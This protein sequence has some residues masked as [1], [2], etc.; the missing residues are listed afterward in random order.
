MKQ[1]LSVTVLCLPGLLLSGAFGCSGVGRIVGGQN[2][3]GS[4]PGSG[5]S[6]P[7][8]GGSNPGTG[9]SNPGTGGN[10]PG[11]GGSNP[12]TGGLGGGMA[13]GGAMGNST[14]AVGKWEDVTP[15]A[16]SGYSPGMFGPQTMFGDPARPGTFYFT[17]TSSGVFKSTD[18]GK[19]WTKISAVSL[20]YGCGAD[21]N[22]GRDPSTP[23]PMFCGG[24]YGKGV[25]RSADN[26]VTWTFHKTNNTRTGS[27]VG[28]QNDPYSMD[29]DPYDNKHVLVGF[30]G[31]PGLSEST[32]G[33]LTYTTIMSVGGEYGTSLYPFFI[34]TGN[35]A[36]TR[37]NWLTMPQWGGTGGIARTTNGGGSWM[38]TNPLK[39][40]HG[41]AQIVTDRSG[42]VYAAGFDGSTGHGVYRSSDWGMTWTEVNDGTVQNGVFATPN[43]IYADYGW[44]IAGTQMQTLQRAPRATGTMGTWMNYYPNPPMR[45]GSGHAAVAFDAS[46]GKYVIVIGAW[47]AGIWRYIEP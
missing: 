37:V 13:T 8:S 7:G 23:L 5:G 32:D 42:V 27:D 25:A 40:G 24:G 20:S 3:G 36:T 46:I 11:T 43:F 26:G 45:N 16:G 18:F 34:D 31:N 6:N 39:H 4:D 22:P 38:I 10:G 15:G 2:T 12:G 21:P 1:F 41:N 9:G 19:T 47:T 14:G 29:V 17:S 44:A 35:A 28:F 33:G 30:H